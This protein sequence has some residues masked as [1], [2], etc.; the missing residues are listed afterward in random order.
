MPED[1][2]MKEMNQIVN[3]G[4]P[5]CGIEIFKG[6]KNGAFSSELIKFVTTNPFATALY[7]WIFHATTAEEHFMSTMFSLTIKRVEKE[8][9]KIWQQMD[10]GVKFLNISSINDNLW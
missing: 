9:W 10:N 2:E 4:P 8:K 1:I 5:P 7:K 3:P 6:Y